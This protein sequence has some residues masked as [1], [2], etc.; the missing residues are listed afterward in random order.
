MPA[1]SS[2]WTLLKTGSEDLGV[3]GIWPDSIQARSGAGRRGARLYLAMTL[4]ASAQVVGS[5]RVGP[6]ARAVSLPTG[7]SEMARVRTVAGCAACA[8]RPPF[9][10]ERCLRTVLISWIAAPH[11][12]SARL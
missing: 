11:V 10:A 6:E 3:S 7:T 2:N 9:T 5:G 8:R 12:T 4:R 1:I